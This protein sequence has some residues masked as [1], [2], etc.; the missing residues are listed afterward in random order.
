LRVGIYD[1]WLGTLG[2]GER[3]VVALASAFAANHDIDLLT[4]TPVTLAALAE[5]FGSQVSR[6]SVRPIPDAPD[7]STI[8]AATADYDLF[9]NA[10]HLDYFRPNGRRNLLLVY[11]PASSVGRARA[12]GTY[13]RLKVAARRRVGG[14][15]GGRA[16]SVLRRA[17]F[18]NGARSSDQTLLGSL[19]LRIFR[20][21]APVR[22]Q[23]DILGGYDDILTISEFSRHWIRRYWGLES[24]VLYPPIDNASFVPGAKC[25][26]ILGVGRFFAGNH[27]KKQD[28]LIRAFRAAV[29]GPLKGWELHLAGGFQPTSTNSAFL[30]VVE[31]AIDADPAVHLHLNCD[32][33][34]LR[35]LYGASKLFWHATGLGESEAAHPERF[36]HFGITTVEAMA[37]GCV[38]LSFAGGGQFEVIQS[39]ANGI[40]W[41]TLDGLI[42][43]SAALANDETRRASLAEAARSRARD[44][45]EAAFRERLAELVGLER[46]GRASS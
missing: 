18:R 1:R 46:I 44:F 45:S 37:A 39:G 27:N 10:S 19:A 35:T 5:R 38:P 17:V 33:A 26:W 4:H 13:N 16:R 32:V 24:A 14:M 40:L 9:I 43:E 2:G 15:L 8:E 25:D 36:E 42:S 23:A 30:G 34:E 29:S 6:T 12:V 28:L 41:S 3:L 22:D 31:Q 7:F 11:F 20:Y 21:L